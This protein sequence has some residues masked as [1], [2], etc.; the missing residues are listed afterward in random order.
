[1]EG[2]AGKDGAFL[3]FLLAE[4][5]V[6]FYGGEEDGAAVAVKVVAAMGFRGIAYGHGSG[7]CGRYGCGIGQGEEPEFFDDFVVGEGGLAAAVGYHL[8]GFVD[9]PLSAGRCYPALGERTVDE[10][11]IDLFYFAAFEDAGE[12]FVCRFGL[13]EDDDAACFAVEAV[14][15]EDVAVFFFEDGT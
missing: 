4:L 6:A 10:A 5:V 7:G 8:A 2:E 14:D 3:F 1:V 11:L 12:V 15:D 13:C 9:A